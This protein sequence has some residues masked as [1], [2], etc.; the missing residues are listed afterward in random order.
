MVTAKKPSIT[1]V[2]VAAPVKTP[3]VKKTAKPVAPVQ[4]KPAPVPAK[5]VAK[6]APKPKAVAKPKATRAAKVASLSLEQRNHYVQVA[7]FYM[8]ERR[9]FA[10]GDPAADWAAAEEEVDRLIASGHFNNG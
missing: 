5:P 4:A 6:V 3:A 7:A 10:A 1:K 8:A 2:P 9:G